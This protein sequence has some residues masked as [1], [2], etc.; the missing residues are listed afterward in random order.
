MY[1]TF[2]NCNIYFNIYSLGANVLQSNFTMVANIINPDIV[3][4]PR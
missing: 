1:K 4:E 3:E 2:S